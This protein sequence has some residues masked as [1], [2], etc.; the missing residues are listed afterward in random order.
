MTAKKG[1]LL[2]LFERLKQERDELMLQ[3]HLGKAEARDEFEE[4]DRKW[5]QVKKDAAEIGDQFEDSLK[6]EWDVLEKK[7]DALKAK[8]E[9]F[10]ETVEDISEDVGAA[11]ELVGEELKRG[12]ARL[13]KLF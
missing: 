5:E 10:T 6:D 3:L 13:K 1:E 11:V 8:A 7:W 9:P 4:L 12:Y 2:Q